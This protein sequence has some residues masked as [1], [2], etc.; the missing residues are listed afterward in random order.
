M[1]LPECIA[2]KAAAGLPVRVLS[3]PLEARAVAL[4]RG[5]NQGQPASIPDVARHSPQTGVARCG[6]AREKACTNTV[7]VFTRNADWIDLVQKLLPCLRQPA[8]TGRTTTQGIPMDR[9]VLERMIRAG[10]LSATDVLQQT[11]V[12]QLEDAVALLKRLRPAK[13]I[14]QALTERI[15]KAPADDFDALKSLYF[16]HC[17]DR[18]GKAGAG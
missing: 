17:V 3:L 9:T 12:D 6:A 16:Q 15:A 13:D 2:R 11:P 18:P 5:R 10:K 8:K 7:M 14:C 4:R 1:T